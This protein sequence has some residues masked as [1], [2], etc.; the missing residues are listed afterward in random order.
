MESKGTGEK[1]LDYLFWREKKD[2]MG[3]KIYFYS[4]IC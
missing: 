3:I 1:N 2:S 4:V